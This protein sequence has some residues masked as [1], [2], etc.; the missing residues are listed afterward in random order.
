[1]TIFFFAPLPVASKASVTGL[2]RELPEEALGSALDLGLLLFLSSETSD[3][4]KV[5]VLASK[6]TSLPSGQQT[7]LHLH[8]VWHPSANNHV[9]LAPLSP[10]SLQRKVGKVNVLSDSSKIN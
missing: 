10:Q 4:R 7:S 9:A 8:R 3:L 5:C 1:M 6:P 2:S